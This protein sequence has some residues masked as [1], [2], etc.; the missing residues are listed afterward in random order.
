MTRTASRR[1]TVPPLHER[2]THPAPRRHQISDADLTAAHAKAEREAAWW[3]SRYHLDEESAGMAA[4]AALAEAT[5]KFQPEAG[6]SFPTFATGVIRRRLR[7]LQRRPDPNHGALD[8]DEPIG[9][10]AHSGTVSG[11][12]RPSNY[13][14][15]GDLVAD[16]AP[17]PEELI[18]QAEEREA[19]AG[20]RS[21]VRAAVMSLPPF[22]RKVIIHRFWIG[23]TQSRLARLLGI[24]QARVF[25]AEHDARE[26]LRE[27]LSPVI[28]NDTDRTDPT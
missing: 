11:A 24:P 22:Q 26:R 1:P 10:F 27:A 20:L 2:G 19:M 16:E 12:D 15:R 5:D 7:D 6:A 25:K 4:I 18:L 13:D 17:G 9:Q 8:L 21:E 14:T 23:T 3:T 28:G